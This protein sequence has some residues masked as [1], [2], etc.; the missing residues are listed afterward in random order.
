MRKIKCPKCDYEWD[1]KGEAKRI[2]C[3][4]CGKFFNNPAKNPMQ[5]PAKTNS[6]QKPAKNCKKLQKDIGESIMTGEMLQ[7][8]KTVKPK[9]IGDAIPYV[10]QSP[11]LEYRL[12]KVSKKQRKKPEQIIQIA[13][14]EWLEK[15]GE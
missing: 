5:K 11:D 15:M 8:L 4:N 1:Y 9:N 13:L 3:V 2:E 14:K 12:A 7:M 10:I 6:M